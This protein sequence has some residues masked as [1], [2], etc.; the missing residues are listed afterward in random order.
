MLKRGRE[1]DKQEIEKRC[2]SEE[3]NVEPIEVWHDFET[4][5]NRISINPQ[6]ETQ[7][8]CQQMEQ[9]SVVA[10]HHPAP[11]SLQRSLLI[12]L[13]NNPALDILM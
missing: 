2:V 6:E 12:H 9:K 13:F 8:M 10:F 1:R 3:M 7:D 5:V 4:K 11:I